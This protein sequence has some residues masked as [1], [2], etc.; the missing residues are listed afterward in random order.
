MSALAAHRTDF[1]NKGP[2]INT[3]GYKAK[4][5]K[6]FYNGAQVAVDATGYL[7]PA[8]A[9]AGLRVA[10]CCDLGNKDHIDTTGT[11]DGDVQIT[12]LSG[13]FPMHI[14]T[15]TDAVTQ[16]D[17]LNDVYVLDDN[18]ISRLPGA[19]RPIS[20]QLIRIVGSLA[21]VGMGFSL[22]HVANSGGA[23]TAYQGKGSVEAVSAAGALS[24]A[25]EITTLAVTGTMAFT[26]ANG[27]FLGQRKSIVVVSAASTP[28]GSLTVATP[29]GFATVS[30]LSAV[31]RS[32]ELIWAGAGAWYIAN[33]NGLTIA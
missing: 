20:G 8:A 1:E 6:V 29:S 33:S 22:P 17:L 2:I 24:V 14:G 26:L 25:T 15:S 18:T 7:V 4:A 3:I 10:G 30:A 28:V 16:A 31:G 5:G 23:G 11:S 32:I 21:W 27:L 9:T 12:V 13:V 19:G